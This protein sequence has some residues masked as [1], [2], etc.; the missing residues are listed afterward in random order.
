M[1]AYFKD[2][3]VKDLRDDIFAGLAGLAG[4]A[5]FHGGLTVLGEPLY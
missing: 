5:G 2:E 1:R 3:V 4:L